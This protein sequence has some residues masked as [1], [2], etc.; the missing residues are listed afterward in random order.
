MRCG[1]LWCLI[2][3]AVPSRLAAREYEPWL[4]FGILL[5]IF[6]ALGLLL[7]YLSQKS[8]KAIGRSLEKS[9]LVI[10]PTGI[11]VKQGDLQGHLRWGELLDIRF[12]TRGRSSFVFTSEE[13]LGGIHLVIAGAKIRI[14]DVYDRPIAL[15]Y[16]LIR[17]Y[18]KGE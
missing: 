10:S 5:S 7:L 3:A 17:G 16:R 9:E 18:W 11:A 12:P 4:V 15:I 6:S 2:Y 13:R 14:A 8:D 1:I